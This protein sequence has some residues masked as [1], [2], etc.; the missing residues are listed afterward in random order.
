M[1][2]RLQQSTAAISVQSLQ[3]PRD[4]GAPPEDPPRERLLHDGRLRPPGDVPRRGEKQVLAPD[5]PRASLRVSRVPGQHRD[6][7]E[8]NPERNRV[9][10]LLQAER[11][12]ELR[13][14][15]LFRV[16][17]GRHVRQLRLQPSE[18]WEGDGNSGKTA[19]GR[20]N[21]EEDGAEVSAPQGR[22]FHG[23]RLRFRDPRNAGDSFAAIDEHAQGEADASEFQRVVHFVYFRYRYESGDDAIQ[24][25]RLGDLRQA[26]EN[27][28]RAEETRDLRRKS[29][30]SHDKSHRRD[31][32]SVRFP[33]HGRAGN[34]RPFHASALS[35]DPQS[36]RNGGV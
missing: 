35:Y 10:K 15:V 30:Q 6:A 26:E 34:Q 4:D 32:E 5:H 25:F 1:S 2:E 29:V 17:L 24:L 13:V 22:S 9:W 3:R 7:E 27:Q 8:V 18:D 31:F 20:R 28:R 19:R 36:I 12:F 33:V 21:S 14:V 11:D 16:R 23:W